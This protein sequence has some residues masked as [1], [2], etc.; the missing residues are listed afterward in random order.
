MVDDLKMMRRAITLARR[1]EGMTSPNPMVG[2]VLVRDGVIVGEGWHKGVGTDHAEVAAL[3]DAGEEARGATAYVTLEPCNHYGN[4]PPCTEGLIEAGVAEVV[5]AVSDPNPVAAGGAEKLNAAGIRIR[6]GVAEDE[7]RAMIRP[8]LHSLLS[9]RPYTFAKL[10]MTLDGRT[11]T[12]TG[13]SKWITGPEARARGH[14]LRQMT[15][16]IM[17]GVGTV[18]ADDPGLDPRPEGQDPRPSR[19]IILDTHLRL[20]SYSKCLTTPGPVVIACGPDAD[21]EKR[22]QLEQAGVTVQSF[23]LKGGQVDLGPVLI[24][25]KQQGCQSLMIEG[26]SKLLGSVFDSCFVDEVWAFIA[27]SIL[28]GGQSAIDGQ[29]P[30]LLSGLH[31]LDH[32]ETEQL[33]ADILIK[34]IIRQEKGA[35]CSL[36][37]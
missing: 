18:L 3:K 11:A 31:R 20:P 2:C 23:P 13:Q 37:S 4:T 10:A 7:A 1:A 33:G 24:W 8:W 32:L 9:N 22:A 19:K 5:Y 29:G 26:G 15:D 6:Q 17:V 34:G 35:A 28:G 21:S 16:A 36:A 12:R 30:S 25:L 14:E 27:P